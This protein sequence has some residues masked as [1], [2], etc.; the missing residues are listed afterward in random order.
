MLK[1]ILLIF[2][3]S[4]LSYAQEFKEQKDLLPIK[5]RYGFDVPRQPA[6]NF[7]YFIDAPDK[8]NPVLRLAVAVQNDYLQYTRTDS[9]FVARFQISFTL[10]HNKETLLTQTWQET[11]QTTDFKTTNSRRGFQHRHYTVRFNKIDFAD[12]ANDASGSAL[13]EVRDLSSSRVY[14]SRRPFHAGIVSAEG[15]FSRTEITFLADS[16]WVGNTPLPLS[17]TYN[18]LDI[19]SPYSV[20]C[21]AHFNGFDSVR[22]HFGLWAVTSKKDTLIEKHSLYLAANDKDLPLLY[23]LPFKQL[24]EGTY[25]IRIIYMDKKGKELTRQIQKFYIRWFLKP[26]YLF[27]V[28]LAI[29]PMSYLL[30]K[31]EIAYTKSLSLPGLQKW[32]GEWWKKRD[33]TPQTSY[34]ELLHEYFARVSQAVV[35]YSNRF[36]EGW[37]TDRG[38]VFLLYGKPDKIENGKYTSKSPPYLIWHYKKIGKDFTFVDQERKGLFQLIDKKEK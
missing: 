4:L 13:I 22:V 37:E 29:R 7:N 33:P 18:T 10:V 30:S 2:C 24:D 28:D 25:A 1:I 11:T 15:K 23:P 6:V 26:L 19:N 32:F 3:C 16:Q 17:E 38:M 21:R 5:S 12:L 14:R 9:N 35:R 8:Q 20:F 27:R 31:K 36:K 34:N